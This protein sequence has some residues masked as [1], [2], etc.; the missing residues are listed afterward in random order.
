MTKVGVFGC[1]CRKPRLFQFLRLF[2]REKGGFCPKVR[3]ESRKNPLPR[4][5][6][7]NHRL[8]S[9]FCRAF[10]QPRK[11]TTVAAYRKNARSFF[12]ADGLFGSQ[13]KKPRENDSTEIQT[14]FLPSFLFNPNSARGAST[15][16]GGEAWREGALF[17]PLLPRT[18]VR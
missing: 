13:Q 14:I 9:M 8:K 5:K 11:Y 3:T 12:G 15:T 10:W 18:S 7:D 6:S 2:C 1:A 4:K 17:S 16:P